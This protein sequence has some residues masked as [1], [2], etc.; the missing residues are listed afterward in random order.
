MDINIKN[1]NHYKGD[2]EYIGRPSKLG[3]PFP[4]TKTQ[5]RK[6]AIERYSIWLYDALEYN[7][8]IIT[9]ELDH[10]FSILIKEQSLTL[11]CWCYPKPCH[12]D[13]IK[14]VLLRKYHTGEYYAKSI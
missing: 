10:L 8:P 7:D 13:I 3:N 4:V 11:L 9:K 5:P 2:G 6:E 14:E 12:G 1:K